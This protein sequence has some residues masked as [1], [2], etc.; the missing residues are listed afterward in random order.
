MQINE[1]IIKAEKHLQKK[2]YELA[3][4]TCHS[5]LKRDPKNTEAFFLLG[6][7]SLAQ[8]NYNKSKHFLDRALSLSPHHLN[9]NNNLGVVF[10]E[11][12]ALDAAEKQFKKVL[13]IDPNHLNALIN[14]GNIYSKNKN[15]EPAEDLY[16]KALTIDP[17]CGSALNNL[18]KLFSQQDQLEESLDYYQQAL[19]C[20]PDDSRVYTGL[21]S[22]FF[23]RQ[24]MNE[25]INLMNKILNMS[26]PGPALVFAYFIAR[27]ICEWETSN[28]LREKIVDIIMN[29]GVSGTYLK[30]LNL[31]ILADP[32]IDNVTLLQI[33]KK[34]A[35]EIE[36]SRFG[37]P[38]QSHETCLNNLHEGNKKLRIGYLSGD[39]CNHVCSHF[40]R[41]L[42]N[43]YNKKKFEVRCYSNTP[44]EDEITDEYK[45]NV[46]A[47]IDIRELTDLQ[48]AQRIHEDNVH[49][50]IELSGYTSN[51][52]L[53]VMSYQPAPMQISYLG[54]PF[55]TGFQSIDYILF[56]PFLD[57]PFNADYCTEL[58]LCLP[59]S[60]FSFGELYD[61][62][63]SPV[64]PFHH[65]GYITFGSLI[66]PYKLNP[67]VI[68]VWSRILRAVPGAEIILNHP[69]YESDDTRKN[70]I[71]EFSKCAISEKRMQFIWEQLRQYSHLR[72]YNDIDIALDSFPMTGGQ[73]TIDAVW[74]GKPVI[75]L[76]G[77]AFHQRISYTTLKNIGIDVEDLISFTQE[78]YI[79]K[80]V[81]LA[82][83]PGRIA[84]LHRLIP[85]YLKKSIFCDPERFASQ[86]ETTL[87]DAWN[88]K[89]PQNKFKIHSCEPTTEFIPIQSEV[90]IATAGSLNDQYTYILK[91][92]KGWFH[93]EY[94]FVLDTIEPNM[95]AIDICPGVGI[96]AAPM[97]KKVGTRGT[98]WAISTDAAYSRMLTKSKQ[99][100]QLHNLHIL[101]HVRLGSFLLD[102]SMLEHGWNNIDFL[103]MNTKGQAHGLL[104]GGSTFF[105][106][107]SPLVMF[108]IKGKVEKNLSLVNDFKLLG[109]QAYRL[110]P[111]LN[112]LVPFILDEHEKDLDV[113]SLHLFCCKNDRALQLENRG[114]LAPKTLPPMEHPHCN[115]TLWQE[116]MGKIPFAT[117]V[118]THW[119]TP[120]AHQDGW[121]WYQHALNFYI[122]AQDVSHDPSTRYACIQSAH[123]ILWNLLSNQA[124][125]SRVISMARIFGDMGKRVLA[126]KVLDQLV[127]CFETGTGS[128]VMNIDEPFLPLS[129]ESAI[130]DP[131]DRLAEWLY[132]SILSHRE[133]LRAFSSYYSGPDSLEAL[134]KIKDLGFETPELET[135]RSL[136]RMRYRMDKAEDKKN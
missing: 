30:M 127:E 91:E 69:K 45:A 122:M 94:K 101:S 64:S 78:T 126:V 66:N 54:Y 17:G 107:L 120:T 31:M 35:S 70:I 112:L 136:I 16:K 85:E 6:S 81:A 123:N 21:M 111:G 65:N 119:R 75:T 50:L 117:G 77:D 84:E 38:F 96:Y 32:G 80:A 51:S 118:L 13:R 41:S 89:Y 1:L 10:L 79:K 121:A 12:Q 74:M 76:V 93:P 132:A 20:L 19:Q 4:Q 110:L 100:N 42:I 56:D 72:Y 95:N 125:V 115:K 24:D 98:V 116:Y 102:Q 130:T 97:A 129:Q 40:L 18:G 7:I 61:E 133:K 58:P 105:S 99:H 114:V 34:T 109:Y 46:D 26:T 44:V 128:I 39:F 14:L 63:I 33:V 124:N 36:M 49:I 90:E 71:A 5:V 48:V 8:G 43:H 27:T 47:F 135:R 83:N 108:G 88:K 11:T 53:P 3:R 131:E 15:W 22:T 113:F 55:S 59:E 86:L 23:A 134:N 37:E 60:V 9:A 25:C 87:I 29:A 57:G 82:N 92:Q 67:E 62:T 73:T 106:R 2:Q 103:L 28:K 52:R 104:K 68:Q